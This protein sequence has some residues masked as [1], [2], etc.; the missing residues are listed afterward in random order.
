MLA[1]QNLCDTNLEYIFFE[2]KSNQL[3]LQKCPWGSL[4]DLYLHPWQAEEWL[5]T[6][7]LP[8]E[9]ATVK[10]WRTRLQLILPW[11]VL[12]SSLMPGKGGMGGYM[13][14]LWDGRTRGENVLEGGLR[15]GGWKSGDDAFISTFAIGLPNAWNLPALLPLFLP[16]NDAKKAIRLPS[17]RREEQWQLFRSL[18]SGGLATRN[19]EELELVMN[20]SLVEYWSNV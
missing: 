9:T 11:S 6:L 4:L 16:V 18:P 12:M 17:T 13:V 19:R 20:V 8:Q 1:W 2:P 3:Q 5:S 15:M 14:V 7:T 10:S